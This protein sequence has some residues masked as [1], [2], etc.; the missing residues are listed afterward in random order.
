MNEPILGKNEPHGDD[1]KSLKI[2]D[3]FELRN[4][5]KKVHKKFG[6]PVYLVGSVLYKEKPRDIDISIIVPLKEYEMMFG[7]L[8]GNQDE[9][10][11]YLYNVFHESFDFVKDLY[12]CIDYH[13]DIKVCPDSWWPEKEK[14]CI[15]E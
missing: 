9:Y 12:D 10:P 2:K 8:P 5:A 13:L 4:A 6:C 14:I 15:T 1:Y 3:Y 7:K 11:E